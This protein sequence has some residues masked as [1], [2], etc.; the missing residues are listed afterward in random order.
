[1][2]LQQSS[3]GPSQQIVSKQETETKLD[4]IKPSDSSEG[5]SQASDGE[6]SSKTCSAK[7]SEQQNESEVVGVLEGLIRGTSAILRE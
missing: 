4:V 5:Y 7:G 1:M 6:D 2:P 3:I